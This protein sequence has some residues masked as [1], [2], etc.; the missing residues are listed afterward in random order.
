MIPFNASEASEPKLGIGAF[1]PKPNREHVEQVFSCY[2]RTV[3]VCVTDSIGDT[4][5][6]NQ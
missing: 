6:E 1:T 4:K 3:T 5:E 2:N